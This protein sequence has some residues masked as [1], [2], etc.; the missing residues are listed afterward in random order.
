[1]DRLLVRDA[2][3]YLAER[4]TAE[5]LA[6]RA[7]PPPKSGKQPS[8][9]RVFELPRQIEWLQLRTEGHC[10]FTLGGKSLSLTLL[11]GIW[12]GE[13]QSLSWHW[14]AG[15]VKRGVMFDPTMQQVRAVAPATSGGG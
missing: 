3:R 4:R 13:F 7:S 6:R 14:P 8:V 15:T 9:L 10:F 5:L 2:N 1:E 11:R 12:G